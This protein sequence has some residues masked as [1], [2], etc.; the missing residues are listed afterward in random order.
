MDS[1]KI[2]L[3]VL[4]ICSC[5][6]ASYDLSQLPAIFAKDRIFGWMGFMARFL[7]ASLGLM[8]E[9]IV[10]LIFQDSF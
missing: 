5:I 4:C 10:N 8:V 7:E 2:L 9:G 1:L 6:E 3:Y